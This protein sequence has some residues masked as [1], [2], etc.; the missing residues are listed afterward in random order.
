MICRWCRQAIVPAASQGGWVIEN[1]DYRDYCYQSQ[2]RLPFHQTLTLCDVKQE[3]IEVL[4][5]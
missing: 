4:L 5:S 1:S 3:L 2:D